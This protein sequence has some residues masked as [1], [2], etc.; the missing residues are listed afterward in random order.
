M[1]K[2]DYIVK[3]I[4]ELEVGTKISVRSIA[5]ELKVSEGTAYKAI[6]ECENIGIVTTVPRIGTI[7]VESIEKRNIQNLVYGE[8]VNIIGG[9]VLGGKD[10][11]YKILNTFVIGAMTIDEM[12]KYIIPGNLLIVGNR[13]EAQ[14]LALENGCAV[15]IT[16]GF[17][18]T[19]EIKELA[20]KNELPIISS[21]YDTFSTATML[22]RVISQNLIKKDIILVEDIM[23][24]DITL[25][26]AN[27]TIKNVRSIMRSSG[28]TKLPV[29][30]NN[31]KLVGVLTI[32]NMNTDI[33][34]ECEVSK[35]MI[36]DPAVVNT[37]TSV[38]YASHIAVWN[39]V[40]IMPVIEGKKLVGVIALNDI[41][42]ALQHVA[43]QEQ[44]GDTIDDVIMRNFTLYK[45]NNN[46]G[47]TGSISPDMLNSLG[48]ASWSTLTH[49]ISVIGMVALNQKNHLNV[50]MDSISV[51]FVRPVQVDTHVNILVDV[52][53]SGR[54][55][56]KLNIEMLTEKGEIIAKALLSAKML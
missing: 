47:F 42:K 3:Y 27:D 48:T 43:R 37:K 51:Y 20:N 24:T 45:K 41:I 17:Q 46:I 50:T 21:P 22:N 15:L 36:R 6:K 19:D 23:D 16:G 1:S 40:E 35:I 7:R 49:I 52:I 39:N 9:S 11:L 2:N 31:D 8:V 14:R 34:D 44:T 33:D 56:S 12:K 26:R 38:A 28:H 5:S 25:V 18:C 13:E 30:D 10:G 53:D 4:K 32:R 29:L 55:F 54:N